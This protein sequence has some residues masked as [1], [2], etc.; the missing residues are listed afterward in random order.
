MIKVLVVEDSRVSQELLVHIL[1]SDSGIK[2][3]G[4]ANNG[5]EAIE[6]LEHNKPDLITMDIVMPKMNGYEATKNIMSTHPLPIV[7]ITSSWGHK[8]VEKIFRATEMGALAVLGKPMGKGFP[9]YEVRSKEIV[10]TVKLMS[11]IKVMKRPYHPR[12]TR[13]TSVL[14]SKVKH[15]PQLGIELIAIGASTGGPPALKTILSHL[16][17]DFAIPVLI[18][19]HITSGFTS[20]MVDWLGQTTGFPIHIA[21]NEEHILPGH[22]YIA[23]DNLQ[24]GVNNSG[25]IA[26]SLDNPEN[27]T[28]PAVSYL[29]RSVAK[30]FGKH[31]VGVL[32]TGMGKDGS[33]ELKLMKEKG[34]ITIAQD[35]ESSVVHGMPGEAI[36]LGAATH[37]LP[38]DYIAKMLITLKSKTI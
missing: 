30:N 17:K 27:G 9:D 18:V 15:K 20:G 24:M 1:N 28:R 29:F 36:K 37:I 35:K 2:V 22:V 34:A 38:P 26:L 3:I 12:K 13:V 19:Q 10:Q 31:A 16:P 11:E 33:K 21:V 32:L 7:M 4:T 14:R 23:P 8:E 25:R 6:F 5:M